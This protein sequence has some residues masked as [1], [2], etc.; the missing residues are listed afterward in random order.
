M[1]NPLDVDARVFLLPGVIE[2]RNGVDTSPQYIC[3]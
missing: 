2:E 3:E 1:W